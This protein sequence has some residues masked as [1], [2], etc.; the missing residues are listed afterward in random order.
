MRVVEASGRLDL[1]QETLGPQCGRQVRAQHLHRHLPVVLEI[2]GEIDR[3]HATG[4]DFPFDGVPIGQG[5]LEA[6]DDGRHGA[7]KLTAA[8]PTSE[9]TARS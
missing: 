3:G 4:T 5:A 8:P 6:F 1:P 7:A 9:W 2:F